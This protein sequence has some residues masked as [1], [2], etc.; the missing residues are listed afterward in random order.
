MKQPDW[1][2]Q[3]LSPADIAAINQGGCASGAYMP[4]VTYYDANKVMAEHGDDVLEFLEDYEAL[5][6]YPQGMN[7]QGM[8]VLFL[9]CAV[10]LFCSLNT[11]LEDWD[12]DDEI[13]WE[14]VA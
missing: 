2:T 4:A 7:W 3:A 9:S 1:I 10:E 8:A 11:R 6:D 14:E 13:D 5:P 12:N